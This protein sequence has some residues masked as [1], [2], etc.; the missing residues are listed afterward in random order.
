[1]AAGVLTAGDMTPMELGDAATIADDTDDGPI[2][3]GEAMPDG[4]GDIA[5]GVVTGVF[6]DGD[7]EAVCIGDAAAA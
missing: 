5:S 6:T 3:A 1:M 7:S 2:A 4:D